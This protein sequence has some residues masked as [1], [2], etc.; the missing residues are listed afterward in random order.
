MTASEIEEHIVRVLKGD[1]L[2]FSRLVREF[3]LPV[4]GY[5][6][7]RLHH[8]DD[9]DDLA[10]EVFVAAFQGLSRF[11]LGESF[12]GWLFGIANHKLLHHYR[13]LKRRDSALER[14]QDAVWQEV[15]Q[16][17]SE[18]SEQA[19]SPQLERLLHCIEALPEKLQVV[20]RAQLR[21]EKVAALAERLQT[22]HGTIYTLH[23]RAMKR[24]RSCM[25]GNA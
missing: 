4:R 5:L 19:A 11:R 7:A 20:V 22:S 9:A 14:F 16:R 21:E 17:V 1:S 6:H 15:G 13:T 18:L 12:Q 10:Q 8:R 24:L 23:W 25:V 3:S 2:A